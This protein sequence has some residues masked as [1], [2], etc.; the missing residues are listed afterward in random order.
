M[1]GDS[2]DLGF[3]KTH[4]RLGQ[5]A[6]ALWQRAEPLGN[7]GRWQRGHSCPGGTEAEVLAPSMGSWG[8]RKRQSRSLERSRGAGLVLKELT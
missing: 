6:G 8:R 2:W 7:P 1:A 5:G 3:S 4:K